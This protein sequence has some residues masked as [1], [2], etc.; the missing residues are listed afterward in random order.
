MKDPVVRMLHTLYG[1][2]NASHIFD[3]FLAKQLY[4]IGFQKVAG[5]S[6][7]YWHLQF[8]VLLVTY[9]DDF[10]A[11]GPKANLPKIW[12]L[13]VENI[14][15]DPPAGIGRFLGCVIVLLNNGLRAI[16]YSMQLFLEHCIER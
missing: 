15:I 12:I 10:K 4:G 13:I 6:G 14:E 9:V 8:R 2:E 3:R 16:Q 7:V 11:A 5:W 1:H